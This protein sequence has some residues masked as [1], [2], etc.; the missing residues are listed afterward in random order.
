[1]FQQNFTRNRFCAFNNQTF[2][3]SFS[4]KNQK[5]ELNYGIVWFIIF[6]LTHFE[7]E[8]KKFLSPV[9]YSYDDL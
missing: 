4:P 8:V 3:L 2:S 6:P 5:N 1:M 7:Q 9:L